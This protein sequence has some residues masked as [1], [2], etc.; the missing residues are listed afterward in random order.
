MTA[1][2]IPLSFNSTA[3][4]SR[5]LL[6]GSTA[7][8]FVHSTVLKA[9]LR[10]NSIWLS[11]LSV[12]LRSRY[13]PA[14]VAIFQLSTSSRAAPFIACRVEESKLSKK[15]TTGE[16]ASLTNV[17]TFVE[18]PLLESRKKRS[19]VQREEQIATRLFNSCG[20]FRGVV[21]SQQQRRDEIT[22][23]LCDTPTRQQRR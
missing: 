11:C 10:R 2:S 4:A 17:C 3:H 13:T 9:T 14:T 18:F 12:L 22:C 7:C 20:R 19:K 6:F 23:L 8:R 5:T 1:G 15:T 21:A 16:Y